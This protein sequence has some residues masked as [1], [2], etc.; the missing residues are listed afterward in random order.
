MTDD[1]QIFDRALLQRRHRRTASCFDDHNFLHKVA[2]DQIHDRLRDIKRD[3]Q[4]IKDVQAGDFQDDFE[5]LKL[6]KNSL[7]LVTS[8]LNLH[9]IN[10]LPGALTQI[11]SSL[12]ADGLFVAAMFGGETLHELRESLMQAEM[13]LKGGVSPRVF[14]FA[15]KQQMGALLQRAGFALPVVDSDIVTVTY[16]NIF[17]LMHDLR[18]M[19]ESNII[20]ERSRT[21]PGKEFFMKAAE[22]YQEHFADREGRIEARFEII[23]LIGWSPHESQQKP[24]KPGSAQSRLADALHTDEIKTGERP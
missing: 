2:R 14:P 23:Y 1:A 12:K 22:H 17:K 9:S 13:Q 18:G 24:L 6:E 10:D 19:G 15:D 4:I 20:L 8:T 3:F 7:D 5:A 11:K 21:N 16:E